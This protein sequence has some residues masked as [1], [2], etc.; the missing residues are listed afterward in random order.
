MKCIGDVQ[1]HQGF[2]VGGAIF[3]IIM[4]VQQLNIHIIAKFHFTQLL[5]QQSQAY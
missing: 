1:Y 2:V 3:E 5:L 4:R